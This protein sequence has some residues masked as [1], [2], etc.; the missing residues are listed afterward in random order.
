[1]LAIAIITVLL[2]YA[3]GSRRQARVLGLM[4]EAMSK[5]ILQQHQLAHQANAR[6]EFVV[7]CLRPVDRRIEIRAVVEMQFPYLDI[8]TVLGQPDE[9]RKKSHG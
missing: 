8:E 7:G 6:Y 5:E 2:L 3:I 9:P 1:M 4:I